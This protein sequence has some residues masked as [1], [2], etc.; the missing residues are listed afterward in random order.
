MSLKLIKNV[1]TSIGLFL[2][3][4]VINTL[5]YYKNNIAL[6]NLISSLLTILIISYIYKDIIIN[7]IKNIKKNFNKKIFLI[8]LILIIISII[9]SEIIRLL[10]KY[11]SFNNDLVIN[12]IKTYKYLYAF[13]VIIITPFL[14]ELIF[15]LPYHDN[16]NKISFIVC[17]LIFASLHITNLKDLIYII[18]YLLPVIG[19]TLNYYKTDNIFISYLLHLINNLIS[20]LLLIWWWYEKEKYKWIYIWN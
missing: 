19:L 9:S 8:G 14:E 2:L 1:L 20:V 16:K 11:D 15:R 6:G 12:N 13:N 7:N 18:P 3:Y 10:F 5:F 17:V 4:L